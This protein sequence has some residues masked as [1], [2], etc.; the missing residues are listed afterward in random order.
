MRLFEKHR[1]LF[2][3]LL[4]FVLSVVH[5]AYGQQLS[6]DLQFKN[7]ELFFEQPREEIFLDLPKNTFFVGEPVKFAG[8]IFDQIGKVPSFSSANVYCSIYNEYGSLVE[9][10]IFY[11]EK[12]KFHGEIK[13]PEEKGSGK[14]YI[15]AY[16]NWMKNFPDEFMFLQDIFLIDENMTASNQIVPLNNNISIYPEGGNL[17]VNVNNSVGFSVIINQQNNASYESCSLSDS[18]GNEVIQNIRINPQGYGKFS[19]TPEAYNQ[20]YLTVRLEGG[21]VIRKPLP[22]PKDHGLTLVLNPTS[23]KN[24]SLEINCDQETFKQLKRAPITLAIHRDGVLKLVNYQM[25]SA[26]S[27]VILP[28]GVVLPGL[29]KLSIF[30]YNYQLESSFYPKALCFLDSINFLFLVIIIN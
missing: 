6:S 28:K 23:E 30:S 8:Y 15:K 18:E 17:I 19:F 3:S 2:P 20:Y 7:Y 10:K 29:N 25:K 27:S 14:Y 12:G 16:T 13:I 11:A 24:I 22:K 4:L 9:S 21:D 1:I 26:N 5:T